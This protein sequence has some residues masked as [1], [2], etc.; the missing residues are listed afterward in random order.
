MPRAVASLRVGWSVPSAVLSPWTV[1]RKAWQRSCSQPRTVASADGLPP[2]LWRDAPP[3]V[4]HGSR[5]SAR[6]LHGGAPRRHTCQP[7]P[8]TPR[9]CAGYGPCA[10]PT[11]GG[12]GAVVHARTPTRSQA[13]ARSASGTRAR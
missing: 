8:P 12:A 4:S 3:H 6:P 1:S 11:M 2:P 10:L 13:S 5:G 7:A 9:T